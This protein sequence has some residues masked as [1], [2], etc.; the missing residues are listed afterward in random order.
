MQNRIN[1]ILVPVY[2]S[3]PAFRAASFAFAIARSMAAS[4]TLLHIHIREQSLRESVTMDKSELEALT[5]EKL[6]VLIM[7]LVGD[8]SYAALQ[9]AVDHGAVEFETASDS[10]PDEICHFADTHNIDL[11]VI[12]SQG[13]SN[14]K[15]LFAGSVSHEVVRKATCPVTVV[16]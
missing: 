6:R 9:S 4:M 13:H 7:K 14:M 5:D 8:P 10:M 3:E 2:Y 12:G 1:N 15:E 16:H 11:I